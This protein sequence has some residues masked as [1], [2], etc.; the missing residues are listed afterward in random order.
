MPKQKQDK[1]TAINQFVIYQIRLTETKN[2]RM[3]LKETDGSAIID[4]AQQHFGSLF[5]GKKLILRG[6]RK[7]NGVVENIGYPNDIISKHEDVYLLRINN[8]VMRSIVAASGEVNGFTNYEEQQIES[9][10]YC[11]VVI[12]NRESICQLAIQKNSAFGDP[13]HVQKILQENLH[14]QLNSLFPIDL[15]ISPKV[16]TS[17]IW[18]FCQA[19]CSE[20]GDAITRISFNFPNQKKIMAANRIDTKYL[21]GMLKEANKMVERTEALKMLISMDYS[22]AEPNVLEK[23]ARDFV[24]IIRE[25]KDKSYNL[26]ISFRDYGEYRCDDLVRAMFP[27]N[28]ELIHSFKDSFM[29]VPFDEKYGLIDWCN[30]VRDK[31]KI[32]ENAL[33]I[34]NKRHRK[35]KR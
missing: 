19:Q 23:H 4:H 10:P 5:E 26:S 1:K 33:Q 18:E 17:K 31:S 29:D 20:N 3:F 11:Y 16:R 13:K 34:P 27:M 25:C 21:K 15:E 12:D 8:R 2:H 6:N 35:N 28:E 7:Q 32:Y 24:N 9:N 22:S 14:E 30:Y